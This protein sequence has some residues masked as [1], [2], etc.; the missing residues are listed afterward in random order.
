MLWELLP[1]TIL[2]D[3]KQTALCCVVRGGSRQKRA[4]TGGDMHRRKEESKSVEARQNTCVNKWKIEGAG[5]RG[6]EGG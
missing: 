2:T 3:A 1:I 6:S 4:W 5:G